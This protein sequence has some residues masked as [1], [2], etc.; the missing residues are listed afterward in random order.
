MPTFSHDYLRNVSYEVFKA[1]GTPDQAAWEVAE[2]LISSNLAG[3][4]SHGVGQVPVYVDRIK[5]GHIVPDAPF[6]VEKETP[7]TAVINGN[8]GFG[9][10][11]T[12]RSTEMLIEKALAQNIAAVTIYRQSHIGRLTPYAAM[13]AEKGLAAIMFTDSG[14][15]PKAVAP[16]GGRGRRLGTNPV[17]I[18]VPSNED[19]PVFIDMA[20]SAVAA[21]KLAVY[22]RRNQPV[23]LGWII[24][25]DGN[26]TTDPN[27][28]NEGGALLPVGGDLGYKGYGLSFMGEVFSGILT[29]LGFGLD[30][31]GK[32]NDGSFIAA[33]RIDAFAD[34]DWF[35]Q[36]VS[37][38]IAF[39]KTSPPAAGSHGVLYPG[40]AE[41]NTEA[42]LR[43]DGIEVEDS[44]WGDI[45][46]LIQE[47]EIQAAVGDPY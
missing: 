15:G 2:G 34:L 3:H 35:K 44:V 41:K 26:P 29:T 20:S 18:C 7:T 36:Q 46:G 8:W 11:V 43:A 10:A 38:F 30:P 28:Y 19:S 16:F 40:E 24:D 31:E 21:N 22:R 5:A 23:P 37:D 32:H 6:V 4:D 25:K 17:C 39:I 9:F 47:Y 42:R 13:C 12:K 33:W 27:A 45:T 1:A 14:R